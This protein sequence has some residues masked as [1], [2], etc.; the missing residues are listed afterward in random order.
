MFLAPMVRVLR[1]TG[2]DIV[3]HMRTNPDHKAKLITALGMEGDLL[4][5]N[6]LRDARDLHSD[7]EAAV[8][9]AMLQ[10]RWQH[11]AHLVQGIDTDHW[12][13]SPEFLRRL[14]AGTDALSDERRT[15]RRTVA[16]C[17]GAAVLAALQSAGGM[18][19]SA[20]WQKDLRTLPARLACLI[21]ACVSDP[22]MRLEDL[23]PALLDLF[24]LRRLPPA[25]SAAKL[26]A[27]AL[28]VLGRLSGHGVQPDDRS[29]EYGATVG[30]YRFKSTVDDGG[31]AKREPHVA[32]LVELLEHHAG[33]PPRA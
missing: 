9:A 18:A 8:G 24:S 22:A 20:D 7:L 21:V 30:D 27:A 26:A 31:E 5:I 1:S 2:A 25:A 10:G 32:A 17:A 3:A 14:V 4:K 12:A 6:A 23:P 13:P 11:A 29:L 16:D 19:L 28:N 33:A 15:Q